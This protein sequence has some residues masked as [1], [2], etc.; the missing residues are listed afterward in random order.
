MHKYFFH[1]KYLTDDEVKYQAQVY[2][3]AK[4]QGFG[5]GKTGWYDQLTL[6][7]YCDMC[8]ER[9]FPKEGKTQYYCSAACRQSAYRDRLLQCRPLDPITH[10]CENPKCKKEFYIILGRQGP[11]IRFCSYSCRR[12]VWREKKKSVKSITQ[13]DAPI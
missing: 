9:I 8:E 10:I 5:P 1:G 3:N 2:E 6:N 11:Q 7:Y 12:K 4:A 13:L